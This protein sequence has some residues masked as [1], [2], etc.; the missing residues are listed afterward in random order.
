ME[1]KKLQ[2]NWNAFAQRDAFWAILTDPAKKGN[3]WRADEFFETGVS[4]I[5]EIMKYIELIGIS[6]PYRKALDFGC[7]V[8]RLTQALPQYFDQVCGVDISPSMIKLAEKYNRYSS[9]CKYYL[10][11]ADN[12]RL[13][14]DNSFDFIY[15]N[16]VL[17]HIEPSYS[18]NYIKDFLRVLAPHGLLIFQLPSE[19]LQVIKLS[20][21]LRRLIKRIMPTA[22]LFLLNKIRYGATLEMHGI[23]KEEVVRFI[24]KNGRKIVDIKQ[25]MTAG[26]DWTSFQ[27]CVMKE[28][29]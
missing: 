14:D 25:N 11:E 8:G 26:K 4:E 2:G 16:I 15:T 18:K 6:M 27:Y 9:K 17:Q 3:K 21:K 12:L 22:L 28:K 1:L 20:I 13:F 24:Q 29:Q 5:N 10:N 19:R 23:K 7:G